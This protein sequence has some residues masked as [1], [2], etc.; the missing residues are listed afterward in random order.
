MIESE[1]TAKV[2]S[3]IDPQCVKV[4]KI[5]DDFQGG[6]PDALYLPKTNPLGLVIPP[7]FVE[8]KYLKTL[9]KREKTVII[10]A[11]SELQ[12]EWLNTAL[13]CKAKVF[14]IVGCPAGRASKGVVF[15]TEQ[16]WLEGITTAEFKSRLMSYDELANF[17]SGNLIG[18]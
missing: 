10:P 13:I 15:H 14:V 6:V 3:K 12:K 7:I 18:N 17:I 2:H 16:E 1:F 5:K 11:L 9:P 4:W 8:Y